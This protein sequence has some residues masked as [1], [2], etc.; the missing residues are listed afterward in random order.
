MRT[1]GIKVDKLA[2]IANRP[3]SQLDQIA[4]TPSATDPR[5]SRLLGHPLV[6]TEMNIIRPKF[7]PQC[8]AEKEFIEAQWHLEIMVACPIH[9]C[10]ALS[11]C[12][13]CGNRLSWF[14]PGLLECKCGGNLRKARLAPASGATASLLDVIRRKVLLLPINE[15]NP[16]SLPHDHLAAMNLRSLLAVVRALGK[17]RMIADGDT[18]WKTQERVVAEAS[19]VLRNWPTNFIQLFADL[20][21]AIPATSTGGV[22]R[23]FASIYHALFRSK[24][25]TPRDQTDFMKIAFLDFAVNH[26]GR[27]FV[28][29]KLVKQMGATLPRRY[30]TRAQFAAQIGV[31]PRT[32]ARLLTNQ[33]MSSTQIKCARLER[34]L[35]DVSQIAIPRISPGKI[36]RNRDA[37]RRLGLSVSV[38]KALKEAGI[39]EVNH[40]LPTQAGFHERDVETFERKLVTLASCQELFTGACHECITLRA[41]MQG[42]HDSLETK[43]SVLQAIL[44][45]KIALIGNTDGTPGGLLLDGPGYQGFVEDARVRAAGNAITPT[46]VA[47]ILECDRGTV[48]GLMQLD[49]LRARSRLLACGSQLNP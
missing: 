8:V 33:N 29:H 34:V 48:P 31:Q 35:V 36:F 43:I 4:F 49:L 41:V 5:W 26:W 2:T 3:A 25:I 16:E 27:G 11:A 44:A 24:A 40:L 1:T 18:G 10:L 9:R 39:Y 7:C 15:E 46:E 22:G 20:G 42:H 17:H 6:P 30:L 14:R 28:D 21:R 12:P 38:L 47:K 45:G 23:Q 19:R 13:K 32:A 37:A